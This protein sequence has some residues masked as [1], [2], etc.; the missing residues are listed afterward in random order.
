M[1]SGR[2]TWFFAAL[3]P[4]LA[5]QALRV[6]CECGGQARVPSCT[7][8]ACPDSGNDASPDAGASDDDGGADASQLGGDDAGG[9]SGQDASWDAGADAGQDAGT[10]PGSF[11]ITGVTGNADVTADAWLTSTASP[12]AHWTVA[13]GATGYA[14]VIRNAGDTADVCATQNTAA[15]SLDFSPCALV[16]GSTYR[17]KVNAGDGATNSTVATNDAFSFTVDSTAPAA[18]TGLGWAQASPT[19]TTGL[20]A[21][22]TRSAAAD[23]ADQKVQFYS[24]AT[25]TAALG[26]PVDLASATAQTSPLTATAGTTYTYRITSVDLAGNQ[27]VS[28]C[29]SG[30]EVD[31]PLSVVASY[32]TN[33]ANWMDYVENDGP[34]VF[35]ST[36]AAC[37]GTELGNSL[38]LHAGEQRKVAVPGVSS[39]TGLS[40]TDALGV[41]TWTCA[42]PAGVATFFSSGFQSGK[43]LANLVTATN[44]KSDS[45]LLTGAKYGASTPAAWWTNPIVALPDNSAG[46]VIVLDDVDDD[47]AGPDQVYTTGTIFT[48]A[49]SRST[50][51]YNLNLD[52]LA[53]V[54]LSGATLSYAGSATK[55]C[56]D[57]GAFPGEVAGANAICVLAAGSQKFLWVEGAFDGSTGATS[58]EMVFAIYETTFSRFHDITSTSLQYGLDTDWNS[59]SNLVTNFTGI[60]EPGSQVGISCWLA[61]YNSFRNIDVYGYDRGIYLYGCTYNTFT[62]IAARNNSRGIRF[63]AASDYN[64]LTNVTSQNNGLDGVYMLQSSFNTFRDVGVSGNGQDGFHLEGS[65]NASNNRLIRLRSSN[66]GNYGLMLSYG[67]N[68]NIVSQANVSNNGGHGILIYSPTGSGTQNIFT[69]VILQSQPNAVSNGGFVLYDA[70]D[71]T[72]IS[73]VTATQSECG[74]ARQYGGGSDTL[75]QGLFANNR[76]GVAL[77]FSSGIKMAQLAFAHHSSRGINLTANSSNNTFLDNLLVGSNNVDCEVVAG[78]TNPGLVNSTCAPQGGSS[79]SLRTT[80]DLS[81][82]FAGK[83]VTDDAMNSSDNNGLQAY[84]SISDFLTFE[85]LFRAWGIDGA[86]F[87]D[88]AAEGRCT[89][90]NCRIW[91]WRL[92]GADTQVRNRSGDGSTPNAPFVAGSACPS[93]VNGNRVITDQ[94]LPPHTFLINALEILDDVDGNDNGLCETGEACI[95]SPNFGAYQGEGDYLAGGTCLFQDGVVTGVSMYAYPTN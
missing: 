28:G 92:N 44:W 21:S 14:V 17:I 36:G 16:E 82:S 38:C 73:H 84:G 5:T 37:L 33:G 13:S 93:A 74:Y 67:A 87:P 3:W 47:G 80:L 85:N 12:T 48:L 78:G 15:T 41:F 69:Q 75:V 7:G 29:S 51:G 90:G 59:T 32:P 1:L 42:T 91:D 54:T 58:A 50:Q 22:W 9:D 88:P 53:V 8:A 89:T 70:S 11:D 19:L 23:L 71:R 31:I 40:L 52:K 49:S 61:S 43:G 94:Q 30:L 46:S 66:N 65:G 62:G 24:D 56:A 86:A 79:F 18:A 63:D 6:G 95:Y 34:D 45:V 39:C 81:S 72:T 25:C 10:P 35:S 76:T 68:N 57:G 64:T 77:D 83:V 2:P 20:T 26:T 27:S 55:N 60:G 4:F